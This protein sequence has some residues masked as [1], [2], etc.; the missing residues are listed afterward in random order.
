[1]KK[2]LWSK[3][4]WYKGANKEEGVD[5]QQKR[6]GGSCRGATKGEAMKTVPKTVLFV[7]YTAMGELVRRLR[8]LMS[9]LAP[10]IGFNV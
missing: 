4:S 6:K 10:I 8:E 7:E 3:T 5:Y 9:R 2:K 1:M